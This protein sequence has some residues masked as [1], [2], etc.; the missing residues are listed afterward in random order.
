MP[1]QLRDYDETWLQRQTLGGLFFK[2]LGLLIVA[3]V[4]LGVV[5]L[6]AGWF[7]AGT[8]IIS[9]QNVKAQWQF[10]YDQDAALKAIGSQWCTA[11]K[12][13]G[14]AVTS[15]ERVQRTSQRIAIEQNYDRN[16]AIYDGKLRDAFRAKWVRPPDMDIPDEAPTL[17]E[18]VEKLGCLR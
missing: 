5:G 6:G 13:E 15:D 3:S 1:R 10:V 14:D 12:A 8:D 9:P 17:T 18:M 7:K 4:V 11:K 16:K 2:G